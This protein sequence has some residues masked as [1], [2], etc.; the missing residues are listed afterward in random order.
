MRRMALVLASTL[1]A[2]CAV[3]PDFTKP[4]A[5]TPNGFRMA[6]PG[7]NA[8]SIANTPWWKLLKDQ[9]LQKLIRRAL[10]ENKDLKRAAAAVEEF[11]A[12]LFISKNDFAPQLSVS[13]NAPSFGRRSVFLVPGFPNPFNYYLQGN[14]SWELDIWGRIRR[15]NEAARGELLSREENRR[16][17]VLQ[18]VSGVAEAYFELLQFDMQLDIARRTLKSW[19]S[20][21]GSRRH[22]CGRE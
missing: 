5:T 12:R 6:E 20:L 9:E 15:S 21:S 1:L 22:D 11:Q 18:L 17:I 7:D 2:A 8:A 16:A 13:A 19:K 10:E 14:L 4:D 3:G